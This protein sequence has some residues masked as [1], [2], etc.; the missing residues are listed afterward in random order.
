V[1]RRGTTVSVAVEHPSLNGSGLNAI[2]RIY[3]LGSGS[4][5]N[6][7]T[8]LPTGND[9][10]GGIYTASGFQTRYREHWN[11][12]VPANAPIGRY[13]VKAI[14][15]GGVQIGA[16]MFYVIHNPYLLVA[17]GAITHEELESYGYD[18]DEDG[19]EMQGEYGPDR[20]WKRDHFIAV[21]SG[22]LVEGYQMNSKLAASFR[23]TQDETFFS[24]LDYA[25]AAGEGTTTE[26][27]T[28]RRY[29]RMVN[30]RILYGTFN[31]LGDISE[32]FLKEFSLTVDEA[33]TYSKPGTALPIEKTIGGECYQFANSLLAI[34]RAGG[35]LSR[36]LSSEHELGGWGNHAFTE[37]YIPNLP[38]HGGRTTSSKTSPISDTDH[39]YAFDATEPEGSGTVASWTTSSEAVSPRSMYGRSGL[40]MVGLRPD[41]PIV[42]VTNPIVWDPFTTDPVFASDLSI[43]TAVYTSGTE[44]W[45]TESGVT[46]WLGY[47]EKDVYRI[48]KTITGAKA[49]RV[50][51]LPSGGEY[52]VPKLCVGSVANTPVMPEK[53]ADPSTHYNLPAGESYVVVF[54]DS[55]NLSSVHGDTVQYILELEW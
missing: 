29:Y 15:P 34:A 30:Q 46:G 38:Q 18:E 12:S 45:L 6:W 5:T 28:M 13:V 17:S 27:E 3:P 51:T 11:L 36:V 22:Q 53:C 7:P 44:F 33:L 43:Q 23:R 55:G 37:A 26:F 41:Y 21:Y 10:A 25:V 50:R 31:D 40:V 39:W 49:V 35:I 19:V 42:A 1:V 47:G 20:D 16:V 24:M 2:L 14:S 54:N 32:Y 9:Y 48:S 8:A 52:L 4:E